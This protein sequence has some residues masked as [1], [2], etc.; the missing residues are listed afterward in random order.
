MAIDPTASG[1]PSSAHVPLPV[2]G[3]L[4]RLTRGASFTLAVPESRDGSLSSTSPRP[5]Q[6]ARSASPAE[7]H[8]PIRSTS[9]GRADPDRWDGMLNR[10]GAKHNV[11][12]LFL[13]AVMLIESG[14]DPNAVGDNGHSVGLFQLHDRGYGHGMGDS[15]FDPEVNAERAARGLAESWQRAKRSGYTGEEMVRAAYDHTFNP[16][17]GFAFQGDKLVSTYNRLLREQGLDALQ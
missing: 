16:G 12:P 1:A 2:A 15:R 10:L 13:K 7:P 11:P 4:A 9:S 14:G 8:S 3:E 6:S 17:G 5:P